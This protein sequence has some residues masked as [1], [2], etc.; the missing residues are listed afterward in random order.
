[1]QFNKP[2][3]RF[4]LVKRYKRF[5]ADVIAADGSPLTIHCPN[6]GAM[7][8]CAE[9]GMSLYA[10]DSGNPKRKYRYT[11]ELS[12]SADGNLIC[13]NTQRA[14]EVAAE[15][16]QAGLIKALTP[17][18]LSAENF[19]RERRYGE[20]NSRIDI[21]LRDQQNRPSFIEVKSVTLLQDG[22]GYFP[23]T[24]S[25]RALKHVQELQ[26]VVQQG[27]RGIMLYQVMHSAIDSVTPAAHIDA[28]YAAALQQ[29]HRA[30]V[31]C[32]A[33]NCHLTPQQ[34]TAQKLLPV[35]LDNA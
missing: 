17:L 18:D 27:A 21:F 22:R 2:L 19:S 23:D 25:Q 13:V 15:A 3:Q 8:G 12:E 1:M 11:W 30:G 28:N 31:E 6:T 34:L 5:L 16:I 9:P 20:Q 32:Y 33:L 14:N 10:S 29:A 7:T 35:M 4:T 24:V 26:H